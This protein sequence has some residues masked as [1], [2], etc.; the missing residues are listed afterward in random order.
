M[1]GPDCWR[2]Y[3]LKTIASGLFRCSGIAVRGLIE[4]SR[5]PFGDARRVYVVRSDDRQELE[6]VNDAFGLELTAADIAQV[7]GYED[8]PS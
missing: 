5:R 3:G 1:S 4:P 6:S 8:R 2:K 7:L